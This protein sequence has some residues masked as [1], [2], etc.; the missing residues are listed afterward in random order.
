MGSSPR[1]RVEDLL[2]I[3]RTPQR[4]GASRHLGPSV[5]LRLDE[6]G[7]IPHRTRLCVYPTEIRD[8]G[9]WLFPAY[10]GVL[11]S[12]T[13]VR[14]TPGSHSS[15]HR[16]LMRERSPMSTKQPFFGSQA[17]GFLRVLWGQ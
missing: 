4:A 6:G 17:D 14:N 1:L 9:W 3:S 8:T 15:G 2:S 16:D 11:Y 7:P 12:K 10:F 13:I 5:Y